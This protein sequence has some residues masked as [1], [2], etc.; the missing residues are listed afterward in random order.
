[1]FSPCFAAFLSL[2]IYMCKRSDSGK[3]PGIYRAPEPEFP[4]IAVEIVG[5]TGGETRSGGGSAGGTA[6][7]IAASLLL[8]A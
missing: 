5:E 4:K 1:M 6:A 3:G 8:K 2:S 7:E